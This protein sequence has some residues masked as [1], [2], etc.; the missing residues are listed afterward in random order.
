MLYSMLL[1]LIELLDGLSS[2]WQDSKNVESDLERGNVSCCPDVGPINFSPKSST[3]SI[4][5]T[6]TTL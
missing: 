5:F 6:V 3:R 4:D 2:A 1:E